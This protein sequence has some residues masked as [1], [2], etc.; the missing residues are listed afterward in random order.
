M[1]G[2]L[3]IPSKWLFENDEMAPNLRKGSKNRLQNTHKCKTSAN[4]PQQL[5]E[6]LR[7]VC[8]FRY[9]KYIHMDKIHAKYMQCNKNIKKRRLKLNN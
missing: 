1:P 4:Q 3:L 8:G 2:I 6:G 9:K 5:F 7:V